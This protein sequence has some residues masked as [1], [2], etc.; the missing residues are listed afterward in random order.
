MTEDVTQPDGL[1]RTVKAL[2][3]GRGDW[4]PKA[5]HLPGGKE[6]RRYL[7]LSLLAALPCVGAATWYFGPRVLAMVAVAFAA[8]AGVEVIFAKLR[9][10]AVRGGALTFAVL[11]A[12]ILPFGPESAVTGA[13]TTRPA[14]TAGQVAREGLSAV[15]PAASRPATQPAGAPRKGIPLWMVA[16]GAAFGAVFGKEIF[17]GTGHHLFSPVL[18]GKGFLM[19]SYPTV[20]QGSYLGSML[21]I[22]GTP[23][24]WVVAASVIGLGAVAMLLVRPGN[25]QAMAAMALAAGALAWAMQSSQRLPYDSLTALLAADG[26]LFGACFLACD[27]ACSPRTHLGRWAYGLLVGGLAV[28]MRCFSNYSEAMLSAILVGN[29][30]APTLDLAAA[31]LLGRSQADEVQ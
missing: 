14:P 26:M 29:L 6:V 30:F 31:G 21:G 11:F 20:V 4:E 7:V 3:L 9:A 16:V 22:E 8:A 17:G 15:A 19:F 13:A 25:W 2:L 5:P 23:Q 27:P 1:G 24:P 10:R 12:L 28:L 18:I